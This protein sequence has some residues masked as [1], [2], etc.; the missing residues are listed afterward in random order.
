MPRPELEPME[1][2][3]KRGRKIFFNISKHVKDAGILFDIDVFE[4]SMLANSFDIYERMS[5]FCN[6][7]K[8]GFT[9]LVENQK[10]SSKQVRP[11]YTIMKNEYSNIMSMAPKYGLTPGDRQKIFNG[12][13]KKVKKEG[14][15]D[16]L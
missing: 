14:L 7:E 5:A 8:N 15:T 9:D 4:L 3:T 6:D 1:Y 13:K 11:E 2:L 16:G 12:L 10:G